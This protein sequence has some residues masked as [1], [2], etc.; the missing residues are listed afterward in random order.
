MEP[1]KTLSR[2]IPGVEL[3]DLT[4]HPDPRGHFAEVFRRSWAED[5]YGDQL[6]VNCSFS[7]A[8]VVRGLHYHLRQVDY[9]YLA[10]GRITAVLVD[11]RPSSRGFRRVERLEL[12]GE[13]PRG[14]WIPRGVAHGYAAREPSSLVYLV[15]RYFDG[16]DEHGLDYADPDLAIDWGIEEPIVSGRDRSN[17]R[18]DQLDLRA[19][20]E[21]AGV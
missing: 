13:E 7:R 12:S 6:Q 11:L 8:G 5:E 17:P 21:A 3:F 1:K 18:M 4:P 9:W 19:I 16:T 14:L 10:A 20:G 2:S 15:S